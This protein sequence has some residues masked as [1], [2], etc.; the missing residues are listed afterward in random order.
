MNQD[1]RQAAWVHASA[2]KLSQAHVVDHMTLQCGELASSKGCGSTES[3]AGGLTWVQEQSVSGA[4]VPCPVAHAM[5]ELAA[6][7]A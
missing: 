7:A 5:F 2:E 4:G 6:A 3:G 1:S